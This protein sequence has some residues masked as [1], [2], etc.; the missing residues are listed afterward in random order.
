MLQIIGKCVDVSTER[1]EPPPGASWSAFDS[2]KIHLLA[3]EGRQTRV[4]DVEVGQQFPADAMP[5]AGED[6]VRLNVTVSG[7][8]TKNGGGYRLT[9]VSRQ[10][11]GLRARATA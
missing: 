3:G 2:T 9:A 7:F 6:D 10:A 8:N 11:V 4:Y 1:R 5:S